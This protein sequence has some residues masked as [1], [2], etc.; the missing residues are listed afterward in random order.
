MA[1]QE[2]LTLPELIGNG[3]D[4]R[5]KR[6][7]G[8]GANTAGLAAQVVTALIGSNYAKSG[9]SKRS[10]LPVPS[11]PEFRKSMEQKDHR[12]IC[13]AG[14]DGMK[15]YASVAELQTL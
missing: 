2:N 7:E 15:R 6:C 4:I 3:Y 8:V 9:A 5:S 12:G 14:S 10:N 13:R 11:V 1:S